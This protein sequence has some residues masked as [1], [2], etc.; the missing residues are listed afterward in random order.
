[1]VTLGNFLSFIFYKVICHFLLCPLRLLKCKMLPSIFILLLMCKMLPFFLMTILAS[2]WSHLSFFPLC[3][4][5]VCLLI[6]HGRRCIHWLWKEYLWGT[7]GYRCHHNR[8]FWS[9]CIRHIPRIRTDGSPWRCAH[10][11]A[12]GS[13]ESVMLVTCKQCSVLGKISQEQFPLGN[14]FV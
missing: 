4:K 1:M 5:G 14:F 2:W 11:R 9:H 10:Y 12:V 3:C 7:R 13:M 6:C 8:I